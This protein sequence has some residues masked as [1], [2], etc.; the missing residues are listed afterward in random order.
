MPKMHYFSNKF[1]KIAKR[2]KFSI[3]VTWSYVICSNCG[4]SSGLWR[5]RTL[6]KS[7]MT[8]LPLRH[9]NNVTKFVHFGPLQSEF[10][11]TP[12]AVV[13]IKKSFLTCLRLHQKFFNEP[14]RTTWK[15]DCDHLLVFKNISFKLIIA[16]CG[17]CAISWNCGIVIQL[18][19]TWSFL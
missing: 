14:L 15:Y 13:Y 16:H 11:A 12:V 1:T 3:L 5:N 17:I 10:L 7:I 18:L 6:K 9:R 8:S 2:L 19:W 4:F